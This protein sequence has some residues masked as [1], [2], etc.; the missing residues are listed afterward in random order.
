MLRKK[1]PVP[2]IDRLREYPYFKIQYWDN[3]VI[4]WKD[5]QMK[6]NDLDS[7]FEYTNKNIS[8]D[9]RTRIIDVQGPGSRK[10]VKS[11]DAFGTALG[12]S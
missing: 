10:I 9:S 7:V 8:K 3:S 5:I 11:V 2:G 1:K 12:L 4:A 6:F